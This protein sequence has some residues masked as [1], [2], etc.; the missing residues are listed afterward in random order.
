MIANAL[1]KCAFLFLY[2]ISYLSRFSIKTSFILVCTRVVRVCVCEGFV[3]APIQHFINLLIHS[4]SIRFTL[5]HSSVGYPFSFACF[6]MYSCS[7]LYLCLSLS[8]FTPAYLMIVFAAR[9]PIPL[10][11]KFVLPIIATTALLLLFCA[12]CSFHFCLFL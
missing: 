11:A 4:C 8:L 9:G 2:L 7:T 12:F 3:F 6:S 10:L 1:V 5:Y